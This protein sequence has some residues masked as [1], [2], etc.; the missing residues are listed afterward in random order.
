M[1]LAL[2]GA[3][4]REVDAVIG[5]AMAERGRVKVFSTSHRPQAHARRQMLL[6]ALERDRHSADWL[7][8][9]PCRFA[10]E[11]AVV[12]EMGGRVGHVYALRTHA[13]IPICHG[14]LVVAVPGK[15]QPPL[16]IAAEDLYPQLRSLLL[17]GRD[18]YPRRRGAA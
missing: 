15:R 2:V 18:R 7:A 9:V 11:V 13:E 6:S 17:A 1:I 16:A 4:A 5:A 12:R 3:D 8:I 10:D 14:D